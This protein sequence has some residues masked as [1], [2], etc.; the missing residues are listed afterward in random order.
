LGISAVWRIT[1]RGE[2]TRVAEAVEEERDLGLSIPYA[3]SPLKARPL[4][5]PVQYPALEA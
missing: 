4:L 3:L 5:S 1:E 2:G